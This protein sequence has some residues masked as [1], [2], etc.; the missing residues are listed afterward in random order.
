[1]DNKIKKLLDDIER[2]EYAYDIVVDDREIHP[3]FLKEIKREIE[4]KKEQ[5]R[6]LKGVE[7]DY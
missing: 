3:K 5:I 4:K 6:L 7:N 2:L 1:M